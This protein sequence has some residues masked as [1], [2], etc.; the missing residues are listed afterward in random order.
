MLKIANK[1]LDICRYHISR[2]YFPICC[3]FFGR[4]ITQDV[5]MFLC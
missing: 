4:G 1:I 5:K 2:Y 3:C